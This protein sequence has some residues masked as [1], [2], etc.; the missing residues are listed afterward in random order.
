MFGYY[1]R[2]NLFCLT[3]LAG[4][5]SEEDLEQMKRTLQDLL[6]GG[7]MSGVFVTSSLLQTLVTRLKGLCITLRPLVPEGLYLPAPPVYCPQP[8]ITQQVL[9]LHL[10]NPKTL[11]VHACKRYSF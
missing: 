8:P 2:L 11:N 3:I 10:F 6:L 7:V 9:C 5:L 4:N 1:V